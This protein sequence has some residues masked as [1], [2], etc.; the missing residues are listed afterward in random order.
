VSGIISANDSTDSL[1]IT[2]YGLA[3]NTIKW[4]AAIDIAQVSDL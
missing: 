2:V 3:S 4:V 1:D